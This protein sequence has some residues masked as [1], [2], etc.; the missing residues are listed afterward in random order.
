MSDEQV[1]EQEIDWLT[2][3]SEWTRFGVLAGMFLGAIAIGSGLAALAGPGSDL[4]IAVGCGA[5]VLTL[6]LGYQLWSGY[7]KGLLFKG[8]FGGLLKGLFRFLFTRQ[9][10]DLEA[11]K[12]SLMEALAD[13]QRALEI[14][15]K[16]RRRASIFVWLGLFFGLLAGLIVA[17]AGSTLG[18]F[19][20]L[21]LYGAVGFGY[22]LALCRLGR[23]GCLLLLD[24]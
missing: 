19:A 17:I 14:S 21:G 5:L 7:A 12:T 18:F 6:F 1:F 8:F 13:R 24:A 20:T 2:R 10:K 22:G 16:I 23:A 9:K 15:R 4:V 11:A 3:H